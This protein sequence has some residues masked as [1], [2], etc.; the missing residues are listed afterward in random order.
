[1]RSEQL[2]PSRRWSARLAFRNAVFGA[3][4]G[5]ILLYHRVAE[6]V[7]D[8]WG[9]AVSTANFAAHM[10]V[11]RRFGTPCKMATL[12]GSLREP[13]EGSDVDIAVTF[14]DGYADNLSR[15]L[16][17]LEAEEVPATTYVVSNAIG[18]P[19]SFWWDRVSEIFL[20]TPEL[21]QTP[22][23]LP[24]DD[25]FPA[26]DR[27]LGSEAALNAEQLDPHMQWSA[28]DTNPS[29]PRQRLFLAVWTHLAA[30]TPK[31]RAS[32]LRRL[33]DWAGVPTE[34][35]D[36]GAQ[37]MTAP[38][39]KQLAASPLIEIGGHT[40]THP[41]LSR[42]SDPEAAAEIRNGRSCLIDLLGH[43]VSSFAYPYGKIGRH[44]VRQVKDAGFDNATCSRLSVAT[45]RSNPFALPRLHVRNCSSAELERTLAIMLGRGPTKRP[46]AGHK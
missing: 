3:P 33:C 16:P 32:A 30:L 9:L 41:D 45:R 19:S 23:P 26:H 39:L 44:T 7:A 18:D 35:A 40:A 34:P 17:I 4:R 6:P 28:D 5:L 20:A 12:G 31:A 22:C 21:P 27:A 11:L 29:T 13:A 46:Q 43:D 36:P 1:M 10:A 42:L 2:P 25:G 24:S 38:E 15:A 37:P 14:D 8:P